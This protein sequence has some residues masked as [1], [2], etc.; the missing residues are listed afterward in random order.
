[1]VEFSTLLINGKP[2]YKIFI[3]INPLKRIV[4]DRFA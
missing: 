3:I 1:M 2:K 4:A